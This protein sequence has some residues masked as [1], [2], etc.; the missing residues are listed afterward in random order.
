MRPI[1]LDSIR[2]GSNQYSAALTATLW[3]LAALR[4]SI[5]RRSTLRARPIS[6]DLPPHVTRDVTAASDAAPDR[7]A[8]LISV[9]NY[10]RYGWWVAAADERRCRVRAL[11]CTSRHR[12]PSMLSP[13]IIERALAHCDQRENDHRQVRVP[14]EHLSHA[15]AASVVFTMYHRH[16]HIASINRCSAEMCCS[17]NCYVNDR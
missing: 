13:Q 7:L 12:R 10:R 6:V 17:N 8:N 15:G 2:S 1:R 11:E 3:R 16:Y 9:S 5:S 14:Y 4:W